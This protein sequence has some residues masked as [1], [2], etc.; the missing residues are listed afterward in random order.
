MEPLT[1]SST[2]SSR[3][4]SQDSAR[5]NAEPLLP[6]AHSSEKP[7]RRLWLIRSGKLY[8]R[9]FIWTLISLVLAGA[10]LFHKSTVGRYDIVAAQP[11]E[12]AVPSTT[13]IEEI[14][15]PTDSQGGGTK[16]DPPLLVVPDP[17]SQDHV[18][19]S[20]PDEGEKLDEPKL[21][22]ELSEEEQRLNRMPWLRFKQ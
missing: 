12:S 6:I 19:S 9:L 11:D 5:R 1:S 22:A 20:K 10:F 4:S 2:R 8:E 13:S 7:A 15:R 3:S 21:P 17:D 18:E 14:P 16:L